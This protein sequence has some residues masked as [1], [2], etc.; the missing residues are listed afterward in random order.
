LGMGLGAFVFRLLAPSPVSGNAATDFVNSGSFTPSSADGSP[1][2][3]AAM[4]LL[5]YV[6]TGAIAITA[7]FQRPRTEV[8][9][10]HRT[11][12]RLRRTEPRLSA[13]RRDVTESTALSEQLSGLR[14]RRR[15]QY[16]LE[17]SRCANAARRVRAEA[18]I[19][20]RQ[21]RR[22]DQNWLRRLTGR[23]A[24]ASELRP[25]AE[26]PVGRRE[27]EPTA[28][29]GRPWAEGEPT[30]RIY[31]QDLPAPGDRQD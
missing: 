1:A 26:P 21:I 25:D 27:D 14:E 28:R 2:L 7:G 6:L 30:L 8:E 13:L 10:Y 22:G 4:L 16:L 19:I 18:A 17:N 3:S 31:P 20:V 9:Q 15:A 29:H 24:V 23:P 11:S 5:L 12:R